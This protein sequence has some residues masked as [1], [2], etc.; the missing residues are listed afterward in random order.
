MVLL[1]R[2]IRCHSCNQHAQEGLAQ[3]PPK[4][5]CR[6]CESVTYF[7]KLGNV[8]D[9]PTQI[10]AITYS[11]N[12]QYIPSRSPSP[13]MSAP[14]ESPFCTTCERNQA[15]VQN[16]IAEY[17]P[18]EDDP[19]YAEYEAGYDDYR[20]E[21]EQRYP[22]VCKDCE[23]RVNDQ[24]RSAGYAA[25]ADH[26]RRI[27]ERSE[28]R[29][30]AAQTARQSWTLRTISLAKWT[31]ILSSLLQLLWHVFSC[32][33]AAAERVWD[34]GEMSAAEEFNW[35][36]CALQAYHTQSV[37][38]SCVMSPDV[39]KIMLYALCAD[40]LTIWWN[41]KLKEKTNSITGRMYGLKSL[42]AIRGFVFMCRVGSVYY[43]RHTTIDALSL[44]QFHLTNIVMI[45]VMLMSYI[46][47]WKVVRVQY[48]APPSF[49]RSV[50]E[51]VSSTPNSPQNVRRQ[52]YKPAHPEWTMLDGMAHSFTSAFDHP[53]DGSALP[54]SPTLTNSSYTTHGTEATTPFGNKSM[55]GD[56]DMDWTPT[57]RGFAAHQPTIHPSPWAQR[58]PSP[59]PTQS[60]PINL[61][62]KPDPNPFHHRVPAIPKAP[63]HAKADP[64]RRGVWDPPLKDTTPNFFK[65]DKKMRGGV[66][67]T[68]GLDGLGVP[69]NVKRD[70]ELFASPKLKYDYYGTMKS[71]GLEDRFEESFNDL[72][73]K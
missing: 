25:K 18:D 42:W 11:T 29:R 61:F 44:P 24:I 64:W 51:P 65:E 45:A 56:D 54:P 40:A 63:A 57:R 49:R 53:L 16:L 17:L 52:S 38:E 28:R 2:R 62:S 20:A 23:A 7:D 35:R 31:Y 47:T 39:M 27:M 72:F 14:A 32:I 15:L 46:C 73:T 6:H 12:F 58:Q 33:M 67:E 70:A 37:D 50:N 34:E 10:T 43:W 66:G 68:K 71:T 26:L 22:Q 19:K 13:I 48:Q 69:K 59:P 5:H 36:V 60:E 8:T 3:V 9:P 21:L 30:R 41:P 55:R 4:Y 1:R